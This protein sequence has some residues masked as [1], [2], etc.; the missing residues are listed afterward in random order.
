MVYGTPEHQ[1]LVLESAEHKLLSE[2]G[3]KHLDFS[4][5]SDTYQRS[6]HDLS[7]NLETGK[8]FCISEEDPGDIAAGTGIL[9][10]GNYLSTRFKRRTR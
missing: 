6:V 5:G 3:F 4:A 2:A 7:I 1:K 10:L 8:W 9:S